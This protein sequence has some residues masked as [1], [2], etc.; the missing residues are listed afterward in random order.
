MGFGAWAVQ[1]DTPGCTA[2]GFGFGFR[3]T[4]CSGLLGQVTW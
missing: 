4:G 3:A 1:P 2:T